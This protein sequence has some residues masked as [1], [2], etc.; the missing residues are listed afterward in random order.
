MSIEELKD[1]EIPKLSRAT[2]FPSEKPKDISS[3]PWKQPEHLPQGGTSWRRVPREV[4]RE[5]EDDRCEART[6]LSFMRGEGDE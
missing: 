3:M 1:S 5:G 4:S 2:K 6:Q